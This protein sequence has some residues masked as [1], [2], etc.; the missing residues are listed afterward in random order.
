MLWAQSTTEDY[1]RVGREKAKQNKKNTR[2]TSSHNLPTALSS[3]VKTESRKRSSSSK[4]FRGWYDDDDDDGHKACFM[5]AR[6]V[7]SAFDVH[8]LT[9][10]RRSPDLNPIEHL[11]DDVQQQLN[12]M[13]PRPDLPL[14]FVRSYSWCRQT[15]PWRKSASWFSPCSANMLSSARMVD[16]PAIDFRRAFGCVEKNSLIKKKSMCFC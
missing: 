11:L 2:K 10:Y 12:Q 14:N 8:I 1:I 4:S 13:Q 5:D 9:S 7:A 15:F 16:L 3:F 6:H